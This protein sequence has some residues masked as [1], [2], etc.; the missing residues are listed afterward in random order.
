[1]PTADHKLCGG[2][3]CASL[4]FS[5]TWVRAC[6][7]CGCGEWRSVWTKMRER[8]RARIT[9]RNDAGCD[10]IRPKACFGGW[11]DMF[12][13]GLN[14]HFCNAKCCSFKGEKSG[15]LLISCPF[16]CY[17]HFFFIFFFIFSA[18]CLEQ[19]CKGDKFATSKRKRDDKTKKSRRK[20]KQKQNKTRVD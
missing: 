1:M 18:F 3:A 12:P 19:V 14:E 6:L 4:I 11:D 15:V 2:C 16:I 8:P 20:A 9:P 10:T 5:A 13:I 17:L 7:P